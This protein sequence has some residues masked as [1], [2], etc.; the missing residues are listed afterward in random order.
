M[1]LA[2]PDYSAAGL[3][4]RL[5][6]ER[7]RIITTDLQT[8]PGC[9]LP[10]ACRS[11][12]ALKGAY[13][14]FDHP[15]TSVEA[16]LPAFT[17]PSARALARRREVLSVHDSTSFNFSHL[18]S[19]TGLGFLNDSITARGIH[20]HSSLLLD[21]H[22]NLVGLG[23]LQ[24]WIRPS[25][26]Q[27]S[28]DEVRK[29]P[30]EEKESYKWLLGMRAVH[31]LFAAP[32]GRPP[33]LI[34]VMDRE[35]D[36]HEVFAEVKRLGDHA[37]IRCAQ[38]RT[39]EA[40]APEQTEAAKQ[41]VARTES[42]GTLSLRVPLKDGGYRTAVVE[43]RSAAVSLRP[44]E[45]KHKGRRRLK[46]GLIE[47]RE[48]STPP[49]GEKAAS[50]WLW[51]TLRVRRLKHVRK[52]LRIYRARWR[53]EDYHRAMKTGCRVEKMRLQEGEKL[54]KALAIA[55]WVATRVVRLR[56]EGKNDPEQDCEE[57]FSSEEWQL[58]WLR[59][60]GRPW[61]PADGKPS[62]GEVIKWLGRLG[63]HLGRNSDPMPG[64][65]CLS[66]ALYALNLLLQGAA[67]GRAEA[68]AEPEWHGQHKRQE[69]EPPR[70][71]PPL[72]S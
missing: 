48:L 4:D 61:R 12:A 7:L 68:L 59:Q 38:N 50:W 14:F 15:D 31:E 45:S 9:S 3:D 5:L 72:A 60:H 62:L 43:V 69:A 44:D 51:T 46:I 22:A 8:H 34:H 70:A 18:Q 57:C 47:V 30:I 39:V 55:A 2:L 26:R 65:E 66:K 56:D 27:E 36:I 35:G 20:L 10:Q 42:L 49:A 37:V 17:L 23:D 25:F 16:I 54:M 58:L 33:R 24:F 53:V 32:S 64:A 41:R 6:R 19:A 52:V 28:A 11:R 63:G 1:L 13:R 71:G 21:E 67:L 29:L 40:D